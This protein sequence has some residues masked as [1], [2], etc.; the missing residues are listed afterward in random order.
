MRN[1][2]FNQQTA[3]GGRCRDKGLGTLVCSTQSE[4]STEPH[5]YGGGM[6]VSWIL[7]TANKKPRT[8]SSG[9]GYSTLALHSRAWQDIHDP[10][11]WDKLFRALSTTSGMWSVTILGLIRML[12]KTS[13]LDHLA[14]YLI[15]E[16]HNLKKKPP[17][18]TTNTNTRAQTVRTSTRC[19]AWSSQPRGSGP[20]PGRNGSLQESSSPSSRADLQPAARHTALKPP[21]RQNYASSYCAWTV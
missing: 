17:M 15:S 16:E 14:A 10:C 18:H 21:W 6:N 8:S 4:S 20:C 19:Q 13:S 9:L 7:E 3:T 5:R 2:C 11:S 12:L 1:L